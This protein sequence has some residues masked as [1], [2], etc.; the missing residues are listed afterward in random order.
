MRDGTDPGTACSDT[1]SGSHTHFHLLQ[2][3]ARKQQPGG[4]PRATAPA[5][6]VAEGEETP[7]LARGEPSPSTHPPPLSRETKG[8][9]RLKNHET[10]GEL[11]EPRE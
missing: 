3:T 9:Q 1:K 5:P 8:T 4:L 7:Q 11:A 2:T 10:T 6:D